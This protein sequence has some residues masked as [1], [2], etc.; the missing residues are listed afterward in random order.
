MKNTIR[1]IYIIS[2][3]QDEEFIRNHEKLIISRGY[4]IIN[5]FSMKYD[6]EKRFGEVSEPEWRTKLL[7]Q[8]LKSDGIIFLPGWEQN[9]FSALEKDI[10]TVCR[11]T[12]VKVFPSIGK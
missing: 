5:P 4:K 10:A 1:T 11:K 12:T 3:K 9:P 7:A 2:D 6:Y 8:L